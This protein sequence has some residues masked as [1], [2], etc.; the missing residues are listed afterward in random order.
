MIRYTIL[1][2]P[3]YKQDLV[4]I[5]SLSRAYLGEII[6]SHFIASVHSLDLTLT[7]FPA[8]FRLLHQSLIE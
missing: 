4:K 1:V 3:T 8:V 7:S 6:R 5:F 2:D